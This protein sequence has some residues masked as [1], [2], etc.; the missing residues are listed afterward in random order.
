M[1]VWKKKKINSLEGL[2]D[3]FSLSI[4]LIGKYFFLI[5]HKNSLRFYF[6]LRSFQLGSRKTR[7]KNRSFAVFFFFNFYFSP[8]PSPPHPIPPLSWRKI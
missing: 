2:I 3:C 1:L 5:F 8:Q 7:K 6:S 4:H